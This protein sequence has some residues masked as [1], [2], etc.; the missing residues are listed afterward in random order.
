MT[1]PLTN[2][3][4]FIIEDNMMNIAVYGALL[5]N[6]G[7]I[8]IQDPWTTNSLKT[9]L[10]R[11][12]VDIIL[13]DLMLRD[14]NSGYDVFEQIRNHPETCDIPVLAVSASDPGIE[15]PRVKA[16]GMNGFI[17]KPIHPLEFPHQILSCIQGEQVWYTQ[18]TFTG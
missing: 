11:L 1:A 15:I 2:K 9:L 14:G 8:V 5:R 13:L 7:A 10:K 12:P 18:D 4:I 16:A 6:T 3:R 17:G